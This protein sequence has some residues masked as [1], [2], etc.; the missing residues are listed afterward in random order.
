MLQQRP[1]LLQNTAGNSRK[2]LHAVQF[3]TCSKMRVT[4]QLHQLVSR[5]DIFKIGYHITHPTLVKS[6]PCAC[7]KLRINL[8]LSWKEKEGRKAEVLLIVELQ[9]YLE[10]WPEAQH[11]MRKHMSALTDKGQ[12]KGLRQHHD[13][14][15]PEN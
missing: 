9:L 12:K 11:M 5:L 4:I 8:L 1:E 10:T 6:F 14:N 13:L 7:R 2:G 3:N 15:L